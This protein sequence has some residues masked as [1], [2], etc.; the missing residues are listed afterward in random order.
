M[1]NNTQTRNDC[2]DYEIRCFEWV[3]ID[4]Y[5]D[6]IIDMQLENIYK[7][8]YPE[9]KPNRDYVKRKILELEQHL[10]NNNT[11]FIGASKDDKLYGYIWCYEALFID[12]K[13]MFVNSLFICKNA[14]KAGLGQL[15]IN[16][17]KKIAISNECRSIATHYSSFNKVAGKFYSNNGFESTRIE[18]V[19][20][21]E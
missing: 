8:H 19:Y 13:R 21:I 4:K 18:M 11:Y 17:A 2:L 6:Q 12:E 16:E 7:F 3:D 5:L 9:R 20:K 14:R 1:P 10:Q 15:L